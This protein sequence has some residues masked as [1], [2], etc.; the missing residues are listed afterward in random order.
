MKPTAIKTLAAKSALII[1]LCFSLQTPKQAEAGIPVID[2]AGLIQAVLT[3][4]ESITQTLQMID[5]YRTQLTQLENQIVNTVNPD[6]WIWDRAQQTMNDL[7][8]AVD[9]IQGYKNTLGSLDNYLDKYADLNYYKNHPCLSNAGC[10]EA[11]RQNLLEVRAFASEAN[12]KA[13]DAMFRG[14]DMQ[15]ET[16]VSDARQLERIQSASQTAGGQVEAIQ[17]ANQLAGN[18]V[19]QLLQIRSLLVAQQN[20]AT[21]MLQAENDQRAQEAAANQKLRDRVFSPSSPRAW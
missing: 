4:L 18:Q 7:R 13:S 21:S 3:A 2:V 16:L 12:K 14:L 1:V 5:S 19:N 15:Q 6:T 8:Q 17:F 9:T 10:S 11:Q 20:V